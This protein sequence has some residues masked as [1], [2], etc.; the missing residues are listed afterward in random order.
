MADYELNLDESRFPLILGT[1]AG[2]LPIEEYKQHLEDLIEVVQRRRMAYTFIVDSNVSGFSAEHR[3]ISVEH[4]KKYE[5]ELQ[6]WQRAVALVTRST[7][8]RGFLTAITWVYTPPYPFK[9]FASL[10]DASSWGIEM[11]GAGDPG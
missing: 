4:M 5:T 8:Q 9:A 7:L 6:R 1:Y 11:A 10:D 2:V 3:R